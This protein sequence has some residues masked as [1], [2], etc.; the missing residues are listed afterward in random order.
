MRRTWSGQS[1][2]WMLVVGSVAVS[3]AVL[4]CGSLAGK[5]GGTGAAVIAPPHGT[6]VTALDA[7][8][9]TGMS[10]EEAVAKTGLTVSLPDQSVVGKPVKVALNETVDDPQHRVGLIVQYESGVILMV[11][12]GETN[13]NGKLGRPKG[14]LPFRDGRSSTFAKDAVA[15]RETLVRD[16]GTQYA[17]S[18][19]TPVP[20]MLLW[21]MAGATYR[22]VDGTAIGSGTSRSSSASSTSLDGSQ[23]ALGVNG[24]RKAAEAIP[25]P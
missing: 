13:L 2:V 18:G 7:T 9:G 4:G 12:P 11:D 17:A 21:S 25:S 15:N 1:I 8:P 16:S 6:V 24:L 20:A 22:L 5:G 23:P 3:A 14:S 10:L 19:D